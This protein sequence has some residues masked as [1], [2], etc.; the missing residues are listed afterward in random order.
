MTRTTSTGRH[1]KSSWLTRLARNWSMPG[2]PR[3]RTSVRTSSLAIAWTRL[4][5]E[6]PRSAQTQSTC[7][8][9]RRKGKHISRQRRK[10]NKKAA[11]CLSTK[12]WARSIWARRMRAKAPGCTNCQSTSTLHIWTI[13]SLFSSY[14]NEANIISQRFRFILYKSLL[15]KQKLTKAF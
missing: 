7:P 8:L 14:K 13:K 3:T 2:L 6:L 5:K 15:Y 1:I 4:C 11:V 9:H 10:G 12:V